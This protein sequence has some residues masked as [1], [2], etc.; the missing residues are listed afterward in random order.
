MAAGDDA[1]FKEFAEVELPEIK[2]KLEAGLEEAA[3]Y[4]CP[5]TR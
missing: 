2:S 1:D 5:K 3:S 4:C